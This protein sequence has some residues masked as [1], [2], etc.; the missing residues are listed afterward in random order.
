MDYVLRTNRLSKRYGGKA[1]VHNLHLNIRQGDIY[2][3]LGQNGAGKTTTL[4]MLMGLIRPT[5]G[6]I[7]LFGQELNRGRSKAAMERIGAIIE[8]PGFYLNLS[9]V[10]NLDI[11]RR[12]MGMGNKEYIEEALSSVGLIDASNQKVKDYSLGMKQRLGI[13]RALL[14]HPELLILD[15]PTNGLDPAGIKEIRQLFL[16]LARLRGITIMI[17]SHLLSEVEQ[18]ATRVGIIHQGSLMEEIDYADLQRKTRHYLELRV[19]DDKKAAYLLEQKLGVSDY[20]VAGPGILHL[21]DFLEQ[22]TKVNFTLTSEGVGVK[23]IRLSG[24][25]LED[26]FL[27]LTGG[28]PLA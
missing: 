15:E 24:D 13:A 28:A 25:S 27:K 20:R 3:F 18:L 10:E 26:Y 14:H 19:D 9:A 16:N 4:R 12:L 11:H 23:E 5:E 6:E 8:Y 2:G 17:S 1:V 7:E 22:S 21:Y